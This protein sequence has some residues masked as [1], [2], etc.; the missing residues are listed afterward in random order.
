MI[1]HLLD[2][3][4]VAAYRQE[5]LPVEPFLNPEPTL[6]PEDKAALDSLGPN[7]IQMIV[8]NA[9]MSKDSVKRRKYE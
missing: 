6:C 2:A 9:W 1:E 4:I 5:P 8:D 3:L 7:F